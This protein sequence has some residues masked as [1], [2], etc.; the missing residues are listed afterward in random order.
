MQEYTL[1]SFLVVTS[2][3]ILNG[4]LVSSK[5]NRGVLYKLSIIINCRFFN[6]SKNSNALPLRELNTPTN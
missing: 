5:G 2:L 3:G 1:G 4:F 6:F